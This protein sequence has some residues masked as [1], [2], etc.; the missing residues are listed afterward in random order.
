MRVLLAP[1]PS[2]LRSGL[3]VGVFWAVTAA[4][5]PRIRTGFP[6]AERT[7]FSFSCDRLSPVWHSGF[8]L[9][10]RRDS[11]GR[12]SAGGRQGLHGPGEFAGWSVG[13][14]SSQGTRRLSLTRPG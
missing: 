13:V 5:L 1:T 2:R 14:F 4:R 6:F 8:Y 12:R 10:E 9:P 11:S 7:L 3:C